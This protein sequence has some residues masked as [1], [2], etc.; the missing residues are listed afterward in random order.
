ML[1]GEAS[2]HGLARE[3]NRKPST[4]PEQSRPD[5]WAN[6]SHQTATRTIDPGEIPLVLQRGL[7]SLMKR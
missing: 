6:V 7:K 3:T 4:V 1:A 2:S 5:E